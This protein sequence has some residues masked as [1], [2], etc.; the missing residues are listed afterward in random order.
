MIA[1]KMFPRRNAR[2]VTMGGAMIVVLLLVYKMSGSLNLPEPELATRSKITRSDGPSLLTQ[3]PEHLK[4]QKEYESRILANIQKMTAHKELQRKMSRDPK[5]IILHNTNKVPSLLDGLGRVNDLDQQESVA[6]KPVDAESQL[7]HKIV[8]LDL[9]GAPPKLEYYKKLFPLLHSFGATG[10][11]IEYEDMFPYWGKLESLSAKNAYGKG[12]IADIM[13]MAKKNNLIVIPLIQT[14]GHMEHVLKLQDFAELRE[15]PNYPQVICP[16]NDKTMPLIKM[17]VD[18]ML[19]LH[20]GIDWLH[21]G[22]DEVYNLG[23]CMRCQRYLIDQKFGKSDLFLHHVKRVAEYVK[24]N[25]DVQPI[26][27]DDEFRKIPLRALQETKVGDL[28]EVMIWKY[29]SGIM[30]DLRSDIWEKYSSIFN[31]LWIASAFKGAAN[32][33]SYITNI[34][35]RLN[36][37]KEWMEVFD[38]YKATIPFRGITLTGWQRFDHFAILCELLPQ[39]VPSL[40]VNLMYIAE[41]KADHGALA[42]VGDALKCN[43]FLNLDLQYLEFANK[44]DYPGSAVYEVTQKLYILKR[45]ISTMLK[46]PHATGWVTDYNIEHNFASPQ[47]VEQGLQDLSMLLFDYRKL[48]TEAETALSDVYDEFTVREWISVNVRP[49][50]SK[51]QKLLAATTKLQETKH[52]PRRPFDTEQIKE[53]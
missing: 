53:L 17:M 9:K 31:G 49:T 23:E 20:P 51:L 42:R 44:C 11:L 34:N 3:S 10:L 46:N 45:D 19:E 22:S 29:S 18:Q 30:V 28:V 2:M 47:H 13:E 40:A 24:K 39:A 7:K 36:N 41:R 43:S 26:M 38:M 15:V 27:W 50:Y 21:I 33:E 32:P 8:H 14:F 1:T 5:G 25:Y 16:T 35:D 12:D 48:M 4:K 52:W 6:L 37:H